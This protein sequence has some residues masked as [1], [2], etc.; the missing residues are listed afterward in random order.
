MIRKN[1][2]AVAA[3]LLVVLFGTLVFI[4][5]VRVREKAHQGIAVHAGIVANALWNH[6][7]EGVS[8]YLML[9]AKLENY[10]SVMVMDTRGNVF[11]KVS[12]TS[13]GILDRFFSPLKLVP[14]QTLVSPVRYDDKIIGTLQAVWVCDTIYFDAMLLVILVMVFVI[15]LLYT[16]VVNEKKM[17][18]NRVTHRTGELSE[19][20]KHLQKEI[21]EHK[22]AKQALEKS[23]ERYRAYFEEN[24]A[25]AYISTPLGRL[26]DCNRKYLDIF[27]FENKYQALNSPIT[28]IYSRREERR[29][30]LDT[31]VEKRK[32]SAYETKFRKTDGSLIHLI[33]NAAAVFDENGRL[34]HIRGFLLDVTEKHHLELQ[35]LQTQKMESIGRLAGGIAHDFNNMLN[36]ILGHADLAL[37]KLDSAAPL[38]N[39]VQQIRNAA[40][41][42]ADITRQLLAFA[43]KQ[44]ISPRVLDLNQ[45]VEGMLTMLRRLLGED[46]DLVWE[47]GDNTGAVQMDPS[48]IHQIMANLCVNA[49]DAIKDVGHITIKTETKVFYEQEDSDLSGVIP[50]E[51]VRLRVTDDGCGM[52]QHTLDNLF[53]PF[54]TTKEVGKGTGLGLSTVYGIVK[55]NQGFI[56]VDSR[57]EKGATFDIFLPRYKDVVVTPKKESPENI[58]AGNGETI[59]VVEDETAILEL[60]ETMLEQLKYTVLTETSP[61]AALDLAKT[62]HGKIHLLITDMV[63]P[64]MNGRDLAR[65][66]TALFPKIRLLFMSGYTDNIIAGQAGEIQQTSFIQKPFSMQDIAGKVHDILS[67]S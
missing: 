4:H 57:P 34:D 22:A 20:N 17:L 40:T 12:G 15:F 53:D 45:T 8:Q 33:E 6:N 11:Q 42:S 9:A 52:D 65:Q 54:F 24:I 36:V 10:A 31:L 38:Y 26:I 16:R 27:G 39:H 58:P 19:L 61:K 63:M 25:G 43:R 35:L 21:E 47:P 64:E 51:F 37:D 2:T 46:I 23:E 7:K 60:L 48:Q 41:H 50:G 67:G 29:Q 28:D 32:V 55:Q 59:L 30:F 62:R 5:E 44:T 1:D 3:I 18:E 14:R 56:H 13:A 66:M 49:R